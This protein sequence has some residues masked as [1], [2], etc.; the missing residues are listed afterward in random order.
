MKNKIQVTI[1]LL[2][3]NTDELI[4][5]NINLDELIEMYENQKKDFHKIYSLDIEIE[6]D[7]FDYTIEDYNS[8]FYNEPLNKIANI[9]AYGNEL[10][11]IQH[12]YNS[13]TRRNEVPELY[14]IQ[15]NEFENIL[16]YFDTEEEAREEMQNSEYNKND[17]Y[18]Y[19]SYST[20]LI[21]FNELPYDEYYQEIFKA[22]LN[23]IIYL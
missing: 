12:M 2:N 21:S 15:E 3:R 17:E 23:E 1:N 11:D 22:W 10:L 8:E 14:D 13:L 19:Y 20:G 18:C 7:E 5:S 16:D 6:F 9:S 4:Q